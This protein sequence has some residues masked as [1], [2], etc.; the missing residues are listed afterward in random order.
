M[1]GRAKNWVFTLNNPTEEETE[2]LRNLIDD[3][4]VCYIVFQT[5]L[6]TTL[7]HQGFVQFTTRKTFNQVKVLLG[8]RAHLEVSRGSPLEASEYCKK[9][10]SRIDGPFEYGELANGG[11]ARGGDGSGVRNDLENFK[12]DV[13]GGNF[14]VALLRD[15]HSEVF[16]KYSKFCNNYVSDV[17]RNGLPEQQFE[18]RV[19]WQHGLM[20]YLHGDPDPRKIRWYID[21]AGGSGKSTFARHLSRIREPLLHAYVITGGRH[22]DIYYGFNYERVIVFDFARTKEEAV[23]WEVIENMKNGYFLSTKY[24][25]RQVHFEIPH[26]I[27]FSNFSPD[28]SKLSADRWDVHII[29]E[30]P[31]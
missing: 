31:F 13:R 26:V 19:G 28:R 14:D 27:I 4:E 7:H 6:V 11:R 23:P 2:N 8:G 24:E 10:E 21:E 16:A 29:N 5:E 30:N 9:E 17:R 3:D 25:V 20:E 1:S 22:T 12:R 15:A 18:P